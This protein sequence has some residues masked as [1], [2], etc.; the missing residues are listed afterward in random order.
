MISLCMIVRDEERNL[1]GFL[2][3]VRDFVDEIIVVD[4]GSKD[5]TKS[6]AKHF[7]KKVYSYRWDDDFSKARNFS[8]SKAK[9]DWILVLDD[10]DKKYND[11]MESL[12]EEYESKIAE[13]VRNN[14]AQM[15]ALKATMSIS[16][17]D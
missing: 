2:E 14:E 5:R 8:I 1:N 16:T 13:V 17:Y 3:N 11:D 10:A 9:K 4:T 15:E 7:T 12:R 6:I